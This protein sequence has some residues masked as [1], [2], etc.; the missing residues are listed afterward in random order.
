M[1]SDQGEAV[2]PESPQPQAEAAPSRWAAMKDAAPGAPDEGANYTV[3]DLRGGT[4]ASKKARERFYPHSTAAEKEEA[5][6]Q[7]DGDGEHKLTEHAKALGLDASDLANPRIKALVQ[8]QLEAQLEAESETEE[9]QE[10]GVEANEDENSEEAKDEETKAPELGSPESYQAYVTQLQQIVS[11]P[12]VNDPQMVAAFRQS[13]G[14]VF[15]A[16]TPEQQQQIAGLSHTLMIGGT[17]L[18]STLVPK[19]VEQHLDRII[20]QQFP[21]LKEQWQ[22]NLI[23]STWNA[24][25]KSDAD[26]RD[27]PDLDS[28]DFSAK[29]E[30][31]AAKNAWMDTWVPSGPDGQPLPLREA[32]AAK[33]QMAAR[34]MAGQK[35]SPDQAQKFI[36]LGRKQAEGTKRKITAGKLGAGKTAGQ[37][38]EPTRGR[39]MLDVY[40]ERHHVV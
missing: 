19:I 15:G 29:A 34:L 2:Q 33:C 37:L 6:R 9:E 13:L 14:E 8:A 23:N 3:E 7:S 20:D 16:E 39:S 21:G 25:R 18:V 24:V 27:L 40:R 17:S 28:D 11:D 36:D 26:F 38:G 31:L 30:E 12:R 22:D 35:I 1:M 5:Q 32:I 10:E 4:E